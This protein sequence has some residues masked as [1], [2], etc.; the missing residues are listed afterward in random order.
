[1]LRWSLQSGMVPL[2]KSS[3]EKRQRENA[4]SLEFELDEEDM[5][6]E[7]SRLASL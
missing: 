6:R 4:A 3:D 5:R 7:S 1:M 2:P